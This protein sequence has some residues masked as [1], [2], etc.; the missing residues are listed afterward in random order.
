MI[1]QHIRSYYFRYFGTEFPTV[2]QKLRIP[3][4]LKYLIILRKTKIYERSIL[5]L[6]LKFR[7]RHLSL[8]THIQISHVTNIGYGF[9]IGHFGRIIINP[10]TQIG[11]NVN[12]STGVVI[13]KSNRG[14]LEG[15]PKISD[16]V[17]IG[18]NAC[19]IGNILIGSNVLIAPN[20]YV[21]I[22]I[23]PDSVVIGNPCVIHPNKDATTGYLNNT[24]LI[25]F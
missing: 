10:K 19:I 5:G 1:D 2:S 8:K 18:P 23:P 22:D 3:I 6:V 14:K 25:K 4:E 24:Y 11:N 21:N 12:I 13:G 17:W 7:L 15:Y 9:Y 20:S 16:N